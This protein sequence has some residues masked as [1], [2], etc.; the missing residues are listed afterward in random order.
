[1]SFLN[2]IAP[3]TFQD[4]L[5]W[6]IAEG[7][8]DYITPVKRC[9]ALH[10]NQPLARIPADHAEF[11]RRFPLEG[12]DPRHFKTDKAYKAWRRKVAA[13]IKGCSGQQAEARAR[14]ARQDEWS[15]LI[16]A[17]E[18]LVGKPGDRKQSH[19]RLIPVR[20]LADLARQHGKSPKQVSQAW[21]AEVRAD[22]NPNEWKSVQSALRRL[23]KF[24]NEQSIRPFLPAS[25][26][27]GPPVLR[28]NVLP[29]VPEHIAEEISSWVQVATRG[30]FDSVEGTWEGANSEKDIMFKTS[31]LRKFVSTLA[32]CT[33]IGARDRL[34]ALL[35]PEN[36]TLV[37]R[38]WT[39]NTAGQGRISAR[40][41]QDY[42][43]AVRTVMARN[44]VSPDVLKQHLANN[45]FLHD[46]K[47]QGR[48][49]SPQVRDFCEMLLGSRKQSLTF[50]SLHVALRN[51]AQGFLD[52][53]SEAGSELTPSELEAVR[54]IGSVAAFCALETR[55]APIRVRNALGLKISGSGITFHL[56]SR[57]ADHATIDI[58]PELTKNGNE[59][60]APIT[61]GNL[62]GLEVIEWYMREIRPLY[63][64]ADMSPYLFP[65]IW[66]DGS[67]NYKTFL[68]WFKRETRLA[69]LPMTPHNFRHGLA[70]LLIQKNPGRWDLLERLLDD[71]VGTARRNYGWVNK[72]TQ[73]SEVQKYVLDLS[74]LN[75]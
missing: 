61:R 15:L 60:W 3:M 55:G 74:G 73:R 46:G 41:A 36:A 32:E 69:G 27:G 7:K 29:G 12:F 6:T 71:T 4:V 63:P 62:N 66:T 52:A 72:R 59:I 2:P 37:I 23:D 50:L 54:A 64:D 22:L 19:P 28:Q 67:L 68:N 45:R 9:G 33:A 25:P 65:G 35:T 30:G 14:R 20:K 58:P 8:K 42:M 70:S 16:A 24:R 38:R 26:Y 5:D 47:K 13:A 57:M 43:K 44:G 48:G 21:L 51:K 34:A 56:P 10:S 17:M 39:A 31:A 1:M 53:C 11:T 49:M 40:T 18:H 75:A